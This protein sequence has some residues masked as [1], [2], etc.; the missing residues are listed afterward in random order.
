M[1]LWRNLVVALVAAFAL[2]ACSSSGDNGDTSMPMPTD[3]GP[4]AYEMAL[5]AIAAAETEEDVDAALADAAAADGITAPELRRLETAAAG[6]KMDLMA[7]ADAAERQ[8]LEMAAMCTDATAECLAAHEA[9]VAALKADDTTTVTALATAEANLLNVRNALAVAGRA[10]AQKM[11]LMDAAGMIDTSD[12]A[13]STQDGV[14]AAKAA[15]VALRAAI[16]AAVDVDDTSTYASQL[17]AAVM[18][19]DDAQDGIDTD[20]RRTNQMAALSA[21]SA[22]LQ[23]ALAALSGTTPTE[24]LLTA[25]NSALTALNNA[26]TAGADLTDDEKAPY[27]RDANQAAAPIQ[28]AQTA[29]NTAQE[30]IRQAER[31][32]E[33]AARKAAANKIAATKKAAIEREAGGGSEVTV[34]PFD[35]TAYLTADGSDNTT[36]NYQVTVKHTGSAVDVT[37][38]DGHADFDAKNDPKFS[39]AASFGN[40]QMLVRNDGTDREIIVLHSDI[41]APVSHRFGTS[42]S[43][44]TLDQDLDTDT[45]ANDSLFVVSTDHGSKLGGSRIVGPDEGDTKTLLQWAATG[46]AAKNVY[47]GTLDGAAGTFRCQQGADCVVTTGEDGAH[48][49]TGALWFTPNA[50]VTVS[51]PDADYLTYGFWLDTTT[52]D[53]AIASY[54]TVQTFATSNLAAATSLGTVTGSATYEGN[55]AGVYVHETKNEDGSL[56]EAKSG[57]FTADVALKAYFD[58][59]TVPFADNS[60]HGTISNFDLDGGPENSWGVNVVATIDDG[61]TLTS[62]T[63]KGGVTG[64]DG[65]FNGNFRGPDAD[66]AGTDAPSVLVGEFN[67]SFVNGEVAGAYGTRK[68]D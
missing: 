42:A 41:E 58:A 33:E 18:A 68:Q 24:E 2:A 45:S 4:S 67:A 5:D 26:I 1:T 17:A 20:T 27:Q 37:V 8:R 13:L 7:A 66:V 59:S 29:Y 40:G 48:T 49:Y 11:A 65:S 56:D 53:G 47:P 36:T 12:E 22:N 34:R 30:E 9:L 6:R 28:T 51:V 60:I 55:A 63:A 35:G 43:G 54:D 57:R 62:G 52:K 16:A 10:D 19:V 25:A 50:G 32:K 61:G 64:Q 44:Y 21:A 23:T 46:E 38:V 15:I 3:P 39:R 14:D 31:D